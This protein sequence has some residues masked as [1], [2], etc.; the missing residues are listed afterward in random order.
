M[1]SSVCCRHRSTCIDHSS[2][3]ETCLWTDCETW[4][5][6][7]GS[8]C[9]SLNNVD[10]EAEEVDLKLNMAGIC[11]LG[12]RELAVSEDGKLELEE[13]SSDGGGR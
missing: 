8:E 13:R 7:A 12:R 3:G 5:M 10:E 1:S 4:T 9:S 2:L 11:M 6:I